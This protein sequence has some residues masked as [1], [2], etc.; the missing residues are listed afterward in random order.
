MIGCNHGRKRG[1]VLQSNEKSLVQNIRLIV[2]VA[3]KDGLLA[4]WAYLDLNKIFWTYLVSL[5]GDKPTPLPPVTN[6]PGKAFPPS[7]PR[8]PT[9]PRQIPVTLS[10]P[11]S[12]PSTAPLDPQ[13]EEGHYHHLPSRSHLLEDR[14]RRHPNVLGIS[15]KEI[16][17]LTE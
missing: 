14:R 11:P 7:P 3:A 17:I 16:M 1:G 13:Q 8:T 5:L 15:S 12:P 6:P 9:S 10:S 4:S 2:P